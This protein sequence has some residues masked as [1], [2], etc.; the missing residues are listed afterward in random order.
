MSNAEA[1]RRLQDLEWLE[2]DREFISEVNIWLMQLHRERLRCWAWR[3]VCVFLCCAL[4]G[5]TYAT[6]MAFLPRS[7]EG[8]C[9]LGPVSC[10]FDGHR[11]VQL[12]VHATFTNPFETGLCNL[13]VQTYAADLSCRTRNT[14]R[15]TSL[16]C[17]RPH[18][19][20]CM[21]ISTLEIVA[22]KI[23][24]WIAMLSMTSAFAIQ[25]WRHLL[26]RRALYRHPNLLL[27]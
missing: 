25:V 24:V 20:I 13:T 11:W 17:L 18:D 22:K 16:H 12:Y 6:M 7:Y 15:P 19:G 21:Y 10:V 1:V 2:G 14:Y 9:E 4:M 26:I 27:A 5:A 8:Q 23:V 3:S